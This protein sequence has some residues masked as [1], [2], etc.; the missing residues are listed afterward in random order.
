MKITTAFAGGNAEILTIE[1][2]VVYLRP[3]LR[4]TPHDWFFWCFAVEEADGRTVTFQFDNAVRVGYYG[5]AVSHD[6]QTWHWQNETKGPSDRFTYTFRKGEGRVYFAH[7]MLYRPERA[8]QLMAELGVKREIL[9]R[10]KHGRDIP[11]FTMG[12]GERYLVLTARQH[13]CESTGSYVLEGILRRLAEEPIS[14][15]GVF[16]VPMVD[17]DGVMDGDQGKGRAPHDHNRDYVRGEPAVY[18]E[19]AAIRHFIDT[20]SVAFG[21][22]C[23]SPYHTGGEHGEHD[24]VYI[25]RKDTG[26]YDRIAAFSQL[27]ESM[28]A[29]DAISYKV[30]NDVCTRTTRW[31]RDDTPDLMGYIMTADEDAIALSFETTYFG[32]PVR[33][34]PERGLAVGRCLAD[35][36]R[37]YLTEN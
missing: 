35:A 2:D 4:D 7:S 14:G 26:K 10:S 34:T 37:A 33:F 36:V 11:Y 18:P 24:T 1:G 22:D 12:K 3:E 23:H 5:A 31:A 25:C 15:I 21:I 9:C 6:Y 19:V 27:L 13:A 8:E 17:Y 28:I 20:H 29:P 32:T 16:C 30:K